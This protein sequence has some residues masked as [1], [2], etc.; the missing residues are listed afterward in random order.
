MYGSMYWG[1]V[2]GLYFN[3]ISRDPGSNILISVWNLFILNLEYGS[4]DFEEIQVHTCKYYV[5]SEIF[6][7]RDYLISNT[8]I[9]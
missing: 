9:Y 5:V 7:L 6:K 3:F 2:V 1:L 4:K 8:I